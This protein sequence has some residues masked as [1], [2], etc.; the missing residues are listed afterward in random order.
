[1]SLMLGRYCGAE[2]DEA[3]SDPAEALMPT[4]TVMTIGMASRTIVARRRRSGIFGDEC[5]IMTACLVLVSDKLADCSC[6]RI[7]HRQ[8]LM[9]AGLFTSGRES[10]TNMLRFGI[11][12]AAIV[13]ASISESAG[14]NPFKWR[15]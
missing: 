11:L 15:R 13:F 5:L 12:I 2:G 1:M 10:P 8:R 9:H 7:S 6:H 4:A 14:N 3:V